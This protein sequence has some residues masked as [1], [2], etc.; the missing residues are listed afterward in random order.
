MLRDNKEKKRPLFDFVDEILWS[1]SVVVHLSL[2][3]VTMQNTV[4]I[5]TL[6]WEMIQNEQ[7]GS[8]LTKHF[9][10]K[11]WLQSGKSRKYISFF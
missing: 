1:L 7:I 4:I 11:K 6:N 9:W 3:V 10:G 8:V 2:T 5:L